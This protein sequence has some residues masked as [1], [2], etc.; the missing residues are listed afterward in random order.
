[1]K[2]IMGVINLSEKEDLLR[3]LTYHRPIA[4]I[5]FGGR[6]RIIDF[7]LSN[8]VNAGINNIAIFS[9]GKSRS[10]MDHLGSGKDWDLHQTT[11]GIFVLN[12][13]I[14]LKDLRVHRGDIENFKNHLDYIKYSKQKYI[15]LTKSYMICNID[16]SKVLDYHKRNQAD[17]TIIYK[18]IKDQQGQFSN[19][20]SL[21]I[22]PGNK[23]L[24]IGKNIEDGQTNNVSMEMYLMSKELLIDIIQGGIRTGEVEYLK[25][26]VIKS[27]KTL[28]NL[29]VQAYQFD[30]YLSCINSTQRYYQAS[31]D[32]LNVDISRELFH[33]N[34]SILTKVKNE[35]STKYTSNAQVTNSLVANG[36]IIEGKVENSIISRGVHIQKGAIVKNSI[37]MSKVIVEEN[38]FLNHTILDKYVH[39][40]KDNVLSGSPKN[41]LGIKKGLRL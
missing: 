22:G 16:Y 9:Q 4:S 20:D 31:Q 37:L 18:K 12:P 39:I 40:T 7:V 8:M 3:E 17:V 30:G 19:C 10:L 27:I 28:K 29:K 11:N 14:D 21:N 23:V 5:P 24:S 2:E 15:L 25:Q 26:A 13:V 32:L 36:C 41:P 6:Y 34:G 38:T 33:Q 1:M 35:A